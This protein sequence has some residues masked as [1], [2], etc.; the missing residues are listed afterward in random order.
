M[1]KYIKI[2]IIIGIIIFQYINIIFGQDIDFYQKHKNEN[3]SFPEIPESMT[4][5]EY[6]LLSQTFRMQDMM[7][8]SV[9]PGYIHFKA[10]EK[11]I[12]YTLL[13][14]RSAAYAALT[15]EYFHYKKTSS[16]TSSFF[17]FFKKET[18]DTNG[19]KTH[20]FITG[21]SL[22][23]VA[24]TYLFDII[25]GKYMLKNKQEKIRFKY[26]VRT[27]MF[28]YNS[29]NKQKLGFTVGVCMYY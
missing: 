8:A 25:H 4:Y 15:Y 27:S 3:Y 7:Y 10:Q 28:D 14:I 16:D 24:G 21:A 6:Y 23:I 17:S 12:G 1:K 11:K 5:E 9:V 18:P 29:M 22:I 26:S 19:E 20:S 2:S 13:G